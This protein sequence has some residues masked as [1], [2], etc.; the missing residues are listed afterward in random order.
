[1]SSAAQKQ[2]LDRPWIVDEHIRRT[3]HALKMVDLLSG[4]ITLVIGLLLFLLTS[5]LLEHWIIPGGWSSSARVVL[6]ALLT[7]G[8]AWYGWRTFWPLVSRPINPVYAA[9]TIEQDSPSLKNSLLNLLLLRSRRQ[10]LSPQ[11]F[12]A[13]EQQAANRLSQVHTDSAVDQSAMLRLAYVMVAVVALCALYRV[14]S[15]KDLFASASRVL[16]PWSDIAAPSRVQFLKIEPGET[17]VARGERLAISAEVLGLDGDEP[18]VL[19]YQTSSEQLDGRFDDSHNGQQVPM[20]ASS[21]TQEEIV[22]FQCQLPAKNSGG[23]QQ[24]L[25][26]W[27]EAGDAR[28]ARYRVSVFARPTMVVQRVRYDYPAYT[29]Y[30]SR[31]VETTGDLRALEGTKVTLFGL[32]NQP[33]KQAYVDF[34]A[35]GRHD[36]AM[37]V[38][39][40][41]AGQQATAT[42]SLELNED[43]RTPRYGSYVLRFTTPTGRRNNQPPKYQIDVT[44]DYGPEIRLIVPEEETSDVRLDQEIRIEVE[45]SDPDFALG[46]VRLVGQVQGEERLGRVLLSQNHTGRFTGGAKITPQELGLRVGDVL[47]YWAEARDNRTPEPNVA[48]TPRQRLRVVEADPNARFPEETPDE[49]KNRDKR[50]S[51]DAGEDAGGQGEEGEQGQGGSAGGEGEESAEGEN[52]EGNSGE[53]NQEGA[54]GDSEKMN[55]SGET[56]SEEENS[57]QGEDAGGGGGSRDSTNRRTPADNDPTDD[58]PQEKVSPEGDDDGSAFERMTDHFAEQD[59][60]ENQEGRGARGEER[61]EEQQGNQDLNESENWQKNQSDEGENSQPQDQPAGEGQDGQAGEPM[62]EPADN[63]ESGGRPDGGQPDGEQ[64]GKEPADAPNGDNSPESI[65]PESISPESISPEQGPSGAGDNPGDEQGSPEAQGR[66]PNDKVSTQEGSD[67]A[68]NDGEPASQGRDGQES[69]SRGGQGGDRS[70]GGQE[71]A[72]QQ[73]DADGQGGAG[74]HQAADEGA[75]QAAEPGEGETSSRPGGDKKA[76]GQTGQ[77]SEESGAGSEKGEAGSEQS[78]AGSEK[79]EQPDGQPGQP[80]EQSG[81][82]QAGN[83]SSPQQQP[84]NPPS[85]QS[86]QDGASQQPL[87]GGQGGSDATPPP[88]ADQGEPG[89]DEANLDYAKQQTDL[90]LDRLADQ[91]DKKQVDRRLLEKLGWSQDELRRFVERWKNLKFKAG[92]SGDDA[93]DAQQE[94]DA[95]LRSLGLRNNR[96]LRYQSQQSKDD[97]RNLRDAGR[98]RIPAEYIEQLRAYE[99]GIARGEEKSEP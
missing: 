22:H 13:I 15:P 76:D 40:Q 56:E 52:G 11:V 36:V 96:R 71:G 27:I 77:S 85:G 7:V 60:N 73:A 63:G 53:G 41:S 30:P 78:E 45:A 51:A 90:V 33:I 31:E 92:G 16:L 2:K 69:D 4:V 21:P 88:T 99:K 65:S 95:A 75:G 94:L 17:S 32:A 24:G 72:G 55:G 79:S 14:L 67:P 26:Y 84:D 20:L 80:G 87:G 49:E 64:P 18:V 38:D 86:G 44:P 10:Q 6:F 25:H 62:D 47:E 66:K 58:A 83:Q 57:N 12:Q 54:G 42:F 37:H 8:V 28:S 68:Q 59:A 43:R 39:P 1:M 48:S 61:G 19:H 3:R 29:G 50:S 9:Q 97:L 82:E 98:V 70:G 46:E 35:D 34:E 81:G 91:L 23:V 5:A 93:S 74:Q 89:G